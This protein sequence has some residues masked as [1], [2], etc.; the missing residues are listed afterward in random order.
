MMNAALTDKVMKYFS[1]EEIVD[2]K[3]REAVIKSCERLYM[4]FS[5]SR[6]IAVHTKLGGTFR[7][8]HTYSRHQLT[9]YI[10]APSLTTLSSESVTRALIVD[11]VMEARSRYYFA[12]LVLLT[13]AFILLTNFIVPSPMLLTAFLI[14]GLGLLAAS[15]LITKRAPKHTVIQRIEEVHRELVVTSSRYRYVSSRLQ[16]I[17]SDVLKVVKDIALRRRD[18]GYIVVGGCGLYEFRSQRREDNVFDIDMWRV[19]GEV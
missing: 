16:S 17:V 19:S 1:P 3:S 10:T 8:Y 15:Y 6:K 14:V 4:L 13:I 7:A 9:L 18:R 12:S 2:D 11:T 5:R